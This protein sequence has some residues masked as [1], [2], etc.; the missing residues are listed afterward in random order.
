MYPKWIFF[1]RK[2]CLGLIFFGE[3]LCFLFN[4]FL[5]YVTTESPCRSHPHFLAALSYQV[6]C[7]TNFS[8]FRNW[9]FQSLPPLLAQW[10]PYPPQAA[11]SA[12]AKSL[13][14][15]P[16]LCDPID[17]SPPGSSILGILQA[18]TLE[19]VTISF[20]PHRLLLPNLQKGESLGDH[21]ITLIPLLC[22]SLL[23]RIPILHYSL[24]N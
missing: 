1:F 6:S 22:I 15:C 18:R 4:P 20:S 23:M 5:F 21:G 16:T 24:F 19:W 11:A 12:A 13:Q 17:G 8:C 10:N 7:P 2:K 14:S 9:H 3:N